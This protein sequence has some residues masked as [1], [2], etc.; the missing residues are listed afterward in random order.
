LL[1][2]FPANTL[3]YQVGDAGFEPATSSL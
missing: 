3:F 1:H 2:I